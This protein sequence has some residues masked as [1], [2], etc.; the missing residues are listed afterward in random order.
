MNKDELVKRVI[1]YL[2]AGGTAAGGLGIYLAER[3]GNMLTAYKDAGGVVTICAGITRINNKPVKMGTKLTEQECQFLNE[4]EA[5]KSIA[6][7]QKNI[8]YP[9]TDAQMVGIASFCPYNIGVGKCYNSTFFKM[10][11]AGNL[12]GACDQ[13]PRWVYDGGKDCNI[14]SNNCYGQV[15]RRQQE[16]ELCLVTFKKLDLL[17]SSQ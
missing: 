4:K 9:L 11:N 12:E 7:V 3:E 15:Q 6:W 5:E 10:I 1:A 8:K 13:I 2:L 16:R 14:R 17:Q